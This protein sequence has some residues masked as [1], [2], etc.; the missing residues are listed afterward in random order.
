MRSSRS[1]LLHYVLVRPT[2]GASP[3][4]ALHDVRGG[5]DGTADGSRAA[6]TAAFGVP[7]RAPIAFVPARASRCLGARGDFAPRRLGRLV[8]GLSLIHI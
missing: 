3:N 6:L 8:R 1:V 4:R 5:G 2:L 7:R